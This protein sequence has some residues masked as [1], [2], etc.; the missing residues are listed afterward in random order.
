M[1]HI[2]DLNELLNAF[3]ASDFYT[4]SVKEY[5]G[6]NHLFIDIDKSGFPMTEAA[7]IIGDVLHNL[8]SAVD[9]LYYR[10]FYCTA[11]GVDHR[12][13]FPI[14]KSREELVASIDGGLKEKGIADNPS[15]MKIRALIV[16]VIKSYKGGN[17]ALWALHDMNITDKHQ[18]LIPLFDVMRFSDISLQNDKEVF[19]ADKDYITESSFHWKLDR[20][21]NLAVKDK[22]HA[23]LAIVFNV[24]TPFEN[25]PVITTLYKISECVTR[26][27]DAFENV[28]LRSHFD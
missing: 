13:R 15:A 18:L 3:A 17:Y 14:R 19:V 9:I 21:G 23:A 24:G 25:Q 1:K 7:L 11:G 2:H 12:T 8:R 27:I 26:T 4:V 22:G 6:S 28:G 16:D 10:A 5:K 20:K